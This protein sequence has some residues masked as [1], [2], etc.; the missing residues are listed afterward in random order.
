MC[1]FICL[2]FVGGVVVE[3][4]EGCGYEGWGGSGD[5]MRGCVG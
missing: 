4:W 3:V 1:V 5:S 2:R